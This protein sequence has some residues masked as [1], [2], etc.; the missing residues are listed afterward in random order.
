MT[1]GTLL[2]VGWLQLYV[3]E[4]KATGLTRGKPTGRPP[5]MGH[6][7]FLPSRREG[8]EKACGHGVLP[9]ADPSLLLL[10]L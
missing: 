5:V 4:A 7:P 10:L 9:L 3:H 6:T 8:A 2:R 1:Q